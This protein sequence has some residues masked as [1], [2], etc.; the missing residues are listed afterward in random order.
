ML[1]LLLNGRLW[2]HQFVHRRR[3]GPT[4]QQR[5][6]Q[7]ATLCSQ[8]RRTDWT[9]CSADCRPGWCQVQLRTCGYH[10]L[11]THTQCIKL[12]FWAVRQHTGAARYVWLF[13][14]TFYTHETTCTTFVIHKQLR[15]LT[16]PD[17]TRPR[18]RFRARPGEVMCKMGIAHAN[19]T[20]GI[21]KAEHYVFLSQLSIIIKRRWKHNL[22]LAEVMSTRMSLNDMSVL[23]KQIKQFLHVTFPPY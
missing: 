3:P 13:V 12:W 17:N 6:A 1:L 15:T 18:P 5:R 4:V 8:C 2:S 10:P 22:C 21:C 20:C 7:L 11:T 9:A 14:C 16:R 19:G 23:T